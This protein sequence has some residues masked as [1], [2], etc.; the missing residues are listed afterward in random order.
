MTTDK[1]EDNG[2]TRKNVPRKSFFKAPLGKIYRYGFVIW[3]TIDLIFYLVKSEKVDKD[4]NKNR[5][6]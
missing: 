4:Y 3:Y 5:S 6:N 2:D 1:N